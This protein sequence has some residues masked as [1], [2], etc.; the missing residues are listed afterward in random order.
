MTQLDTQKQR[1]LFFNRSIDYSVRNK[2]L[3]NK[4]FNTDCLSE[5]GLSLIEDKSVDL[6]LCDLPYGITRCEF[7]I[8]IPFKPLWKE[9]NRIIK[10]KGTILLFGA[11]PFDIELAN[12]NIESLEDE[13]IWEKP[14]AT[15]HLNAKRVPMRS[16]ETILVF[17]NKE[18]IN[19]E[20]LKYTGKTDSYIKLIDDNYEFL[21]ESN[22]KR[23]IK[24]SSDTQKSSIHP[25]QKPIGLLEILIGLYSREGDLVVDN[26]S[27]SGSTAIACINK[28][29]NYICFEKN[30][31]NYICGKKRI[32]KEK[33]GD[34]TVLIDRVKTEIVSLLNI[35]KNIIEKENNIEI[36]LYNKQ[37]LNIGEIYI[38]QEEDVSVEICLNKNSFSG[39]PT[40]LLYNLGRDGFFDKYTVLES[41]ALKN[42]RKSKADDDIDTLLFSLEEIMKFIINNQKAL[43]GS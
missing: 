27:G 17:N 31:K 28:N 21:G 25:Q 36:E 34:I 9:Y 38:Y 29:R 3:L 15:G 19:P 32:A 24:H 6:I 35:D 22:A 23:I 14:R 30:K 18:I 41:K 11:Y 1:K 13:W 42:I 8:I 20:Y 5:N 37:K 12:S 2:E 7:D 39:N 33:K 16:H 26:A 10:D 43:G 4:T 40:Q